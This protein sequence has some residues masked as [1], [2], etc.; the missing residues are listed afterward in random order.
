VIVGRVIAV[1]TA[2]GIPPTDLIGPRSHKKLK[3]LGSRIVPW[4][5]LHLYCVMKSVG[6]TFSALGSDEWIND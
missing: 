2:Y 3:G 4:N 6:T 1:T 5:P